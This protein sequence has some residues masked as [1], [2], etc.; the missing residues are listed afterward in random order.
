[1]LEIGFV[2]AAK[3][4]HDI[5][6]PGSE[7]SSA[8]GDEEAHLEAMGRFIMDAGPCDRR[9]EVS[10]RR[11]LRRPPSAGCTERPRPLR[12]GLRVDPPPRPATGRAAC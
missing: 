5:D 12:T 4:L 3:R 1:M 11:S 10:G 9:P 8:R 7:R 6:L 2:G